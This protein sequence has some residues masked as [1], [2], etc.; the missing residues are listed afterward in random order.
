MQTTTSRR[1]TGE[2]ACASTPTG[3]REEPAVERL[4][5]EEDL[6]QEDI[7]IAI[8]LACDADETWKTLRSLRPEAKQKVLSA[9]CVLVQEVV[10]DNGLATR[11]KDWARRWGDDEPDACQSHRTM[12]NMLEKHI[13]GITAAQ[14][15]WQPSE[16]DGE[17]MW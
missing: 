11:F 4:T 7:A 1:R 5:R 12:Y 8:M 6:L 2:E 13:M 17:K 9:I 3:P 15:V 16:D 10:E 14:F